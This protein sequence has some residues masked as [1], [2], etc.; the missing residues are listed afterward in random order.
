ME[1][2]D[3]IIKNITKYEVILCEC[4]DPEHQL[5]ISYDPDDYE[6]TLGCWVSVYLKKFN[7]W[8]RLITAVKY[9]FGKQSIYGVFDE[10]IIPSKDWQKIDKLAKHLKKVDFSVFCKDNKHLGLTDEQLQKEY[11]TKMY[12]YSN[13]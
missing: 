11:D 5:I 10:I 3:N 4:G 2:T 6:D 9:L 8:Q 1:T 13:Q 7:F 12:N